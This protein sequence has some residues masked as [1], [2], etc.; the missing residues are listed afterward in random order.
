MVE[1]SDIV[2]GFGGGEIARDEL[3]AAKRSGKQV[4]FFPAEMNHQKAEEAARKKGLPL[5]TDFRGA[6]AAI[7]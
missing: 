4:R 5:P 2:V 3:L 7:F 1:N 6:A